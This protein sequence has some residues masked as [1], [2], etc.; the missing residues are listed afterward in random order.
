VIQVASTT[1]KIVIGGILV[2]GVLLL[3]S[4]RTSQSSGGGTGTDGTSGARP[5]T[6]TVTADVLNARSNP[7]GDAPVVETYRKGQIISADRTTR[8]GFRQL[9]PDRWAA[10]EFL[11]PTSD[12][13][14]D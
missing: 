14:C 4:E 11:E 12:S 10:Q 5:C 3:V 8:N 2:V 9:R 13:D 7:D 1:Q 6:V